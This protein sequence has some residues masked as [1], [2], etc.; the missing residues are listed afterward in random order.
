MGASPASLAGLWLFADKPSEVGDGLVG[1]Y[2]GLGASRGRRSSHG[3]TTNLHGAPQTETAR[4]QPGPRVAGG[5]VAVDIAAAPAREPPAMCQR[6]ASNSAKHRCQQCRQALSQDRVA[7]RDARSPMA[8]LVA[9]KRGVDRQ[10]KTALSLSAPP[11]AC[12]H[13]ALDLA[14]DP[15]SG[16][17]PWSLGSHG[18]GRRTSHATHAISAMRLMQSR[19]FVI[20]VRV[21]NSAGLPFSMQAF[22][23]IWPLS[24]IGWFGTVSSYRWYLRQLQ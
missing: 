18:T 13:M 6:C 16:R 20:I 7:D 2:T 1:L 10:D 9:K 24:S 15:G 3:P 23:A 14:T 21:G 17:P 5:A 4:S 8:L 12:P 22:A 11:T 19:P